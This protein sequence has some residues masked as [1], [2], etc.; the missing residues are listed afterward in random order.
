MTQTTTKTEIQSNAIY[1]V[2]VKGQSTTCWAVPSD[3][4]PGTYYTVCFDEQATQWTCTCPAGSRSY[5]DCKHRRAVQASLL[6][7]KAMENDRLAAEVKRAET[8]LALQARF[9]SRHNGDEATRR[10]YYEM[11]IGY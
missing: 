2:Q 7:S 10:C 11:S 5:R 1:K 8:F 4:Q 9:D 3:S 6:A